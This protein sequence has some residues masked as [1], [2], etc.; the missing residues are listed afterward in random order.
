MNALRTAVLLLI[1]IGALGVTPVRAR[2]CPR[3][4]DRPRCFGMNG[5]SI[6]GFHLETLW[7]VIAAH[8]IGIATHRG[9]NYP[10][11]GKSANPQSS[12]PI[13]SMGIED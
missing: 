13:R 8:A 4:Y 9:R 10:R 2:G 3:V 11:K 12:I 5:R 1:G 7:A 6:E